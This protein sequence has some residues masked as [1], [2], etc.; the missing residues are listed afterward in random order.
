MVDF[1]IFL[2]S[3]FGNFFLYLDTIVI[4]EHLTLLRL[5]LILI[6]FYFVFKVVGGFK[7]D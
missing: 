5:L 1:L 7:N 4:Y 6:L 3:Q 2:F